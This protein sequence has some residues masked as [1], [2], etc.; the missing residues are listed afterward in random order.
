MVLSVALKVQVKIL[1]H[2]FFC[3]QNQKPMNYSIF[4]IVYYGLH[5]VLLF[6]NVWISYHPTIPHI[7]L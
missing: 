4:C 2:F 7:D 5:K 3:L 6:Y 1:Q